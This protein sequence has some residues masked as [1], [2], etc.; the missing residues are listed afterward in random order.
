MGNLK[1]KTYVIAGGTGGVGGQAARELLDAGHRVILLGRDSGRGEE[2]LASFGTKRERAV[3]LSV[4]LSTHDGVRNAARQ[5]DEATDVIDGL[6]HSAAVFEARDVRTADNIPVFFA[7]SYLSRYHLTQLLLPKLLAA[8]SPRV[9]MMVATMNSVPK[10]NPA[11]FRTFQKFNFWGMM[12]AINGASLYYA[13]WLVKTCPKIFAG[14][15][16]PGFV[17]TGLFKNAPWFLRLNAAITG[18][19]RANTVEVAAHNPV[20]ALLHGEGTSAYMWN[21]PGDFESR[22]AIEVDTAVQNELIDV[23]REHTGV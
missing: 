1:M 10:L 7:L 12:F 5:I 4:D 6:L 20:Q 21:K 14:C 18:P 22:F 13:D 2:T 15:M 11:L 8:E 3:F 23:S 9:M 17:R 19:F 16:T